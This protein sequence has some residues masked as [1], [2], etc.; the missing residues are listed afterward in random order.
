MNVRKRT[1]CMQH[2]YFLTVNKGKI[3]LHMKKYIL[4]LMLAAPMVLC[5]L[6]FGPKS[7]E[8]TWP[9]SKTGTTG[10]KPAA[11][12]YSEDVLRSDFAEIKNIL[13][14]NHPA[15]FRFSSREAFE[16]FY[17][18]QLQK[19]NRPMNLGEYFLVAAP[20]VESIHCGHT[21]ISLPDEF[22]DNDEALFFPLGMVFSGDKAYAALSEKNSPIPQGS[23]IISINKIPVSEI[24]ES[25]K[26]LVN[27]DA[28]SK[29]GKL[30]AFF[31]SFPDLFALQ[32]GNPG[33]YEV[34]FIPPG[35]PEIQAHILK[36]VSRKAA[37]E[38]ATN[39]LA[40]SFSGG[41]EL[42]L[43]ILQAQKIAILG[44][45]SF[46]YYN[47]RQKFYAFID[48]AF[49]QIQGSGIQ[50]LILDLRNNSGG[51][52]FCSA[53]LL[54]YLETKP[55]PYFARVYDEYPT[56]AQPIPVAANNAFSGNLFVLINGGCFSSTGHLCALLKYH[57][58]GKFIGEETGG[59]YECN[60]SQ[61]LITTSAT[62]LNLHLAR[63]TYT[64]AVK[65]ISG[66]TGIMPD[67]PVEPTIEDLLAGRDAVKEFAMNL[68][69]RR[70]FP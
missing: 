7:G 26:R 4:F 49:K 54:S 64:I 32:Y 25:T 61:T 43:E 34:N 2:F 19:M 14:N 23:E 55:A 66:E 42:Q 40:G 63:V 31:H 5:G 6:S 47:N 53:H 59:N 60:D 17:N 44:I 11:G 9:G 48:S 27:S 69:N 33:A 21:W 1:G 35:S 37:W 52:P 20:L 50:T 24:I 12:L 13:L 57:E 28:K 46:S 15:P 16:D 36:P 56:L 68:S 58:R 41:D 8:R 51:D 22:W 70:Q 18:K 3:C 30:A 65:G 62:K 39:T 10:T 67:Y 38:N 29:T 45:R